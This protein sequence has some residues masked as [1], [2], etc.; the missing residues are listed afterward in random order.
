MDK[1]ADE[2][3][4]ADIQKYLTE[5][6]LETAP[7]KVID[8]KLKGVD[9]QSKKSLLFGDVNVD[10]LK[11]D[12]V[13]VVNSRSIGSNLLTQTIN[14]SDAI[15]ART[16]NSDGASQMPTNDT[17]WGFSKYST[18][19]IFLS[20]FFLATS[21]SQ[22]LCRDS[23]M[24]IVQRVVSHILPLKGFCKLD[25]L[26][27]LLMKCSVE[28]FEATV[29]RVVVMALWNRLWWVVFVQM[30]AYIMLVVVYT[31]FAVECIGGNLPFLGEDN[32]NPWTFSPCCAMVATTTINFLFILKELFYLLAYKCEYLWN[33]RNLLELA[34]GFL[35]FA[36][37]GAYVGNC[38]MITQKVLGH[39]T[40]NVLHINLVYYLKC[41]ASTSAFI[42]ITEGVFKDALPYLV[43]LV[44]FFI[45]STCSV[46]ILTNET[47][48]IGGSNSTDGKAYWHFASALFK[49]QTREAL[50][51]SHSFSPNF[52]P[53]LL[54][55]TPGL[56]SMWRAGWTLKLSPILMG[57]IG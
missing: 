5:G 12:T 17:I 39:I 4:L 7:R 29:M 51:D 19:F 10:Q 22:C 35:F 56:H 33:L 28:L 57:Q 24:K 42:R 32:F 16:Q 11:V 49:V 36:S 26:K 45:K 38:D 44:I 15:N 6:R 20:R 8:L 50:F 3:N 54:L 21:L 14:A 2:T 34:A 47:R 13:L 43:V 46:V 25:I 30:G 55:I 18:F 27:P 31:V 53:A 52:T 48:I 41:F 9:I 40:I 1:E 23:K 37:Y